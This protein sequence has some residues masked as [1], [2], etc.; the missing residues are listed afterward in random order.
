MSRVYWDTMLFIY[1]LEDH[2]KHAAR[3]QAIYAGMEKRGDTL[4]TSAFTLGEVLSGPYRQEATALVP[5]IR[6]FFRSPHVELLPF[7]AETADHYARIRSQRRRVSPADAIHLA[8]AAD[9]RADLFL[10]NDQRLR[11]LVIPGVDFVAGME[12]D[13]F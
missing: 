7:T 2:P 12:V 13:L 1:W 8:T 11:G 4:C 3:V 5:Q 6:A 10:T 9:A